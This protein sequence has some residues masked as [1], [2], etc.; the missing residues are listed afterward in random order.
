M[1]LVTVFSSPPA[2]APGAHYTNFALTQANTLTQAY[3]LTQAITST[4]NN[5]LTQNK[6]L[7]LSNTLTEDNTLTQADINT[8]EH[9][10]RLTLTHANTN[11][12]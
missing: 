3:T 12:G 6:T 10:D 2:L 5:K 11:T 7:A 9:Q 1:R 8:G 4:Q